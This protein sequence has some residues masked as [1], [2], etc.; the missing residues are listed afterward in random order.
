[1]GAEMVDKVRVIFLYH[2]VSHPASQPS[3]AIRIKNRPNETKML[4]ACLV[5]HR[6]FQL[7]PFDPKRSYDDHDPRPS[8][9]ATVRSNGVVSVPFVNGFSSPVFVATACAVR[10][11]RSCMEYEI[12]TTCCDT[13]EQMGRNWCPLQGRDGSG[14]WYATD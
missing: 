3:S 13:M 10:Y 14:G 12:D 5:A 11:F 8:S 6:L 1:M 2:P 7:H 4:F 9:T